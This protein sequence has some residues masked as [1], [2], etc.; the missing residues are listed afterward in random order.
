MDGLLVI[1]ISAITP[2]IMEH[3]K[4]SKWFP[5]MSP[6]APVAN[7]VTPLVVAAITAAGVTVGFDHA[8]G[9]LTISGLVASDVLRGLLLWGVGMI[10]QQASYKRAIEVS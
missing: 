9:V 7:R 3:L 5:F 6:F 8:T 4:Y 2:W 1:L 10:T